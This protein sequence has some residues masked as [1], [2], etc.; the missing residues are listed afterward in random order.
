[1]QVMVGAAVL[2][3]TIRDKQAHQ[4]ALNA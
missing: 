1:L 2:L 3:L 4:T